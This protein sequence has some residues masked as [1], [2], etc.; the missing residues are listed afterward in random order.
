MGQTQTQTQTIWEFGFGSNNQT[1]ST[2]HVQICVTY[3]PIC[4][5]Q[6][7]FCL[8]LHTKESI[9]YIYM[10]IEKRPKA[11][12]KPK[13]FVSLGLVPKLKPK[14]NIQTQTQSQ[15]QYPNSKPNSN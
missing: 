15:T 9:L 7:F 10:A 3:I 5:V 1:L 13:L 4:D 2:I 6:V 8:F 12:L 14:L 11:K